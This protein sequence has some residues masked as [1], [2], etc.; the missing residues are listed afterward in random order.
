MENG[1]P[2]QRVTLLRKATRGTLTMIGG[3]PGALPYLVFA[4]DSNLCLFTG[5]K[6]ESCYYWSRLFEL[7]RRVSRMTKG[8]CRKDTDNET[9]GVWGLGVSRCRCAPRVRLKAGTGLSTS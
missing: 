2:E 3:R 8:K 5:V 9:H 6:N 7:K 1:I 4:V